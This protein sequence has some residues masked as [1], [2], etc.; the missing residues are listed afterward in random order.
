MMTIDG[1]KPAWR[2]LE[3]SGDSQTVGCKLCAMLTHCPMGAETQS[4]SSYEVRS[5]EMRAI[6]TKREENGGV[7]VTR[8]EI[9]LMLSSSP[10][11]S[12]K[13]D[14]LHEASVYIEISGL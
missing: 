7:V 1:T 9:T 3:M 5:W 11:F 12:Q 6:E 8:K 4:I 10:H 2:V 14:A 13:F